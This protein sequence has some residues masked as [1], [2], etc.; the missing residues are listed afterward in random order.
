MASPGAAYI[1]GQ[2]LIVDGGNSI[3]EQRAT[4]A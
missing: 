2:Y 3:A 1:T 4:Q